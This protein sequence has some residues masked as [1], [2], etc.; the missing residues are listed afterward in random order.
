[1]TIPPRQYG[2]VATL[3]SMHLRQKVCRSRLNDKDE[4]AGGRAREAAVW[5]C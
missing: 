1:M 2:N 4:G 5:D 3:A